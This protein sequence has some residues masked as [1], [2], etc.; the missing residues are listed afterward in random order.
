M[1][2]SKYTTEERKTLKRDQRTPAYRRLQQQTAARRGELEAKVRA[3][4]VVI[5]RL[6]ERLVAAGV[7]QA[8][9]SHLA[10]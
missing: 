10:A 7:D 2:T 4:R 9:V 6:V 3:Q 5:D 8:E 1:D